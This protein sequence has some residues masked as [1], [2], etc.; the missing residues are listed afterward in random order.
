[1]ARIYFQYFWN[2]DGL[3]FIAILESFFQII[4]LYATLENIC[5]THNAINMKNIAKSI[6]KN[7]SNHEK[8]F[9]LDHPQVRVDFRTW[10]ALF[11]SFS[12]SKY[13]DRK[14]YLLTN[15]AH[16]PLKNL[17]IKLYPILFHLLNFCFRRLTK[18]EVFD[19]FNIIA[20]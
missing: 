14:S 4:L 15:S 12:I 8:Y 2:I 18:C 11:T 6:E 1:M 17:F 7:R 5:N 20:K 16:C 3:L 10:N 9:D 13:C 19:L